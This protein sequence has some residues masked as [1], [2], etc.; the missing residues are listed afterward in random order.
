MPMT[1]GWE[2]H[3]Q[4]KNNM[5]GRPGAAPLSGPGGE[6]GTEQA[7]GPSGARGCGLAVGPVHVERS[8]K[9]SPL[10][11]EG[12]RLEKLPVK[13]LVA[14]DDRHMVAL[15]A[16]VTGIEQGSDTSSARCSGR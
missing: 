3:G 16:T 12:A 6:D 2:G 1:K 5:D 14:G 9:V 8:R 13:V 11:G 10:T 7:G 15:L 4:E